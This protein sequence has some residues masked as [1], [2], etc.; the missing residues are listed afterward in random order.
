MLKIRIRIEQIIK[1]KVNKITISFNVFYNWSLMSTIVI[2]VFINQHQIFTRATKLCRSKKTII[3]LLIR[4]NT[5]NKNWVTTSRKTFDIKLK[6][7]IFK[8]IRT[9]KQ[10]VMQIFSLL[11]NRSLKKIYNIRVEFVR[12]NFISII[13]YIDTY[14]FVMLMTIQFSITWLLTSRL[15]SIQVRCS[16]FDLLFRL[17]QNQLSMF[18]DHDITQRSKYYWIW[19]SYS[20]MYV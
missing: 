6:I 12:K 4:R 15:R 18:F 8:K 16:L 19:E 17:K 3:T 13:N 2:N 1:I 14:E 10:L 9:T 7:K 20:Q 11:N 5:K